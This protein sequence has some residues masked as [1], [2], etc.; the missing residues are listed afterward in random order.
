MY[1]GTQRLETDSRITIMAIS[2][3][4]AALYEEI[5]WQRCKLREASAAMDREL[6]AEAKEQMKELTQ[7]V[8]K[9]EEYQ[10]QLREADAL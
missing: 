4:I 10:R 6:Y 9:C 1:N 7:R 8:R 5:E 3:R 2:G